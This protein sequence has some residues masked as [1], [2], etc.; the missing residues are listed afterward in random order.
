MQIEEVIR[1]RVSPCVGISLAVARIVSWEIICSK[2]PHC[3][4]SNPCSEHSADK[5]VIS[6]KPHLSN[7]V[8]VVYIDAT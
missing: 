8:G 4:S 2:S 7:H 3:I 1:P 5:I 6:A